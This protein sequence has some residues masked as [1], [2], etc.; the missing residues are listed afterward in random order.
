MHKLES[1]IYKSKLQTT[2]EEFKKNKVSMLGMLEE[3][4]TLLD[5]AEAGGGPDHQKRLAA[6]GKLPVRERIFNFLDP[7]SPF[8]E[9]SGLAGYKSDYP[10]G[11]GAV[12]GIGVCSGIE[13]IIFA[14][15]PTVLAGAMH[16]YSVKKWMR[17]M[18]LSLIHI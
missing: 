8:L 13:C 10:V 16:Y 4:D 11:G 2:S 7:D 18:A 5:E 9:I 12:A 1:Q 14:N 15:D 17:S 6:R 3:I